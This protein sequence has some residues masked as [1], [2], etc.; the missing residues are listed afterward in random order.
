[1]STATATRNQKAAMAVPDAADPVSQLEH[2]ATEYGPAAIASLSE[3]QQAVK[4]SR[5][6]QLARTLITKLLPEIKPL[7]GTALGFKTD[8]DAKGGYPDHALIEALTEAV[9]RGVSWTGNQFNVI[10]GRC[11]VTKEGYAKLVRN[12][13]GLTDLVLIPGVPKGGEGGAVVPFKAEWRLNGKL[14]RLERNI[15]VRLNG[16]AGADAA[17][18]K[19]T[20][21]MLASVYATCTGSV[22]SAY[23]ADDADGDGLV[24]V[25]PAPIGPARSNEL[26]SRLAGVVGKTPEPV[27]ATEGEPVPAGNGRLFGDSGQL[28]D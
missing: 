5:G 25:T 22:Q 26:K 9:L 17:I 20:R 10:S 21:K 12:L 7:A 18:G 28:P 1:M 8:L 15:P 24:D 4:V 14:M 3:M 23:D 13:D 2:L 19:A 16:T 6:I 11:Y 27:P